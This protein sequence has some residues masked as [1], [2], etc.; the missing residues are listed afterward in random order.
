MSNW[1][2]S[3]V[4]YHIYPLGF[5]G[6]PQR[7]TE[8]EPVKRIEKLVEWIP[9]LKKLGV[10]ALYLGPVF[11]SS[12]H[13]YDTRDYYQIDKRLGDNHTFRTV[14]DELHKNGIRI[15]LDG[16]F[17]HV[18]REFWAFQDVQRNG[19][20]SHY[21]S[22]F[23]NLN[24]GGGSPMGDPFWYESWQGHYNLV[25]LNLR[26]QEVV[27]HLLGAVG[28][29]MQDFGIDGL[30]LDAADCVDPDFFRQLRRFCKERK[31]D[32]WLMG[33]IIH[34]DY[35]R[36]ANPEMLDS[37]TNYE[38]YKGLYSSHND[39]NYFEI[40]Y[41]INRQFGAGGGI[42]RNIYTY[43][44]VDNHDVNRLASVLRNSEHI[45][46]V[47]T[48][49]F[50]MPGAPSVYYGSEWGI[51]GVKQNNS[52]APLR[53]C[54]ELGKIPDA[55]EALAAHIG[56]LAALRKE[57]LPLQTGEYEQVIVKN[58]QLIF[59]RSKDGQNVYVALNL[60]GEEFRLDF[61]MDGS[62]VLVDRLHENEVLVPQHG[63]VSVVVPACSARVLQECAP[64]DIVKVAAPASAQED[65]T[66][67]A[68][69][70]AGT[71]QLPAPQEHRIGRYRHFKGNEY[72]VIGFA[73]DSETMQEKVV[74]QALYGEQE[75]WVRSADMFFENVQV[76]GVTVPRFAYLGK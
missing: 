38:C 64:E 22:W 34:G 24:F 31:P 71:E 55:N 39:K 37:V 15:V 26:N 42:Y 61:G 10:N 56:K 62:K 76:N 75:L 19:Q 33:E 16:V 47:Y 48:L 63:T 67:L 73:K 60:G 44:F 53:P 6:A 52:D 50:T 4:F 14:C 29:W 28:E 54:L 57:L 8:G 46:N 74:Y 68:E 49:L 23:H 18:G 36:W 41:S 51:Q 35:N 20:G 27:D 70:P 5:C 1:I 7:N 59:K 21:C 69:A 3:A 2:H 40:N 9:H 66:G 72:R 45:Y 43:N 17:N 25:K 32:F 58:E 30:R 11:E 13:G 12:E 65:A